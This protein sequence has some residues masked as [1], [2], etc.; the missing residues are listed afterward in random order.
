[1]M[2]VSAGQ[3][4]RILGALDLHS[5]VNVSAARPNNL[6]E[7]RSDDMQSGLATMSPAD[8]KKLAYW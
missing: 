1:M 5:S 6:T 3:R 7:A 8:E 4:L 2:N